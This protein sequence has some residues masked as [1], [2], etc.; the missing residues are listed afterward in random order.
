[1]EQPFYFFF[2]F[3]TMVAVCAARVTQRSLDKNRFGT[4][5]PGFKCVRDRPMWAPCGNC[6]LLRDESGKKKVIGSRRCKYAKPLPEGFHYHPASGEYVGKGKCVVRKGSQQRKIVRKGSQTAKGKAAALGTK[7]KGVAQKVARAPGTKSKPVAKKVA[8]APG[9]KSKPVVARA[10]GTKPKP[11]AKKAGAFIPAKAPVAKKPRRVTPDALDG[12]APLPGVERYSRVVKNIEQRA[13]VVKDLEEREMPSMPM[14][15]GMDVLDGDELDNKSVALLKQFKY[16]LRAAP[17]EERERHAWVNRVSQPTLNRAVEV[18]ESMGLGMGPF[19]LMSAQKGL[20]HAVV[21]FASENDVCPRTSGEDY[22]FEMNALLDGESVRLT[23]KAWEGYW[24]VFDYPCEIGCR[25]DEDEVAPT[26]SPED[27]E[28][29]EEEEEDED[30]E[31]LECSE[32]I[33]CDESDEE[34]EESEESEE[35]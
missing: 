29:D 20:L 26:L 32:S 8:R 12:D 6:H 2:F 7:S 13:R 35:E 33:D 14:F 17:A 19:L 1:M 10:P 34:S 4:M 5:E 21:H 30:E 3:S 9:T 11:V 23:D 27:S 15:D 28:E 18:F 16:A 22:A 24:S 31:D 25:V